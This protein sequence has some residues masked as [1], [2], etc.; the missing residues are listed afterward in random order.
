M[1]KRFA[2]IVL[3]LMLLAL[4]GCNKENEEEA[5]VTAMIELEYLGLIGKSSTEEDFDSSTANKN[6]TA[7][8][9]K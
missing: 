7:H 4:T 1:M 2:K 3:I 6:P 8:D 9:I 5:A